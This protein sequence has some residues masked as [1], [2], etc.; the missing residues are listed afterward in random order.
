M[1]G[2]DRQSQDLDDSFALA[3]NTALTMH[4]KYVQANTA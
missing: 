2:C 1:E 4:D 3:L